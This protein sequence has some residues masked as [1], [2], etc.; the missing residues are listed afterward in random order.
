MRKGKADNSGFPMATIPAAARLAAW[1]CWQRSAVPFISQAACSAGSSRRRTS[2]AAARAPSAQLA[3][4]QCAGG[5]FGVNLVSHG[6]SPYD[7]PT[8]AR[9]WRHCWFFPRGNT[10]HRPSAR[11][12]RRLH[13]GETATPLLAL[14]LRRLAHSGAL[15][16]HDRLGANPARNVSIK[17]RQRS[18]CCRRAGSW[19]CRSRGSIVPVG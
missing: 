7:H 1:R 9:T 10:S 2:P 5:P 19:S 17:V 13:R 16:T 11:K 18:G 4:T 8:C 3:L 15:R 6:A 14:R 12:A